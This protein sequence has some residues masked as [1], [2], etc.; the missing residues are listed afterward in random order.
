MLLS[1]VTRVASFQ[2]SFIT[3]TNVR[4]VFSAKAS[5]E[6][7]NDFMPKKKEPSEGNDGP[8]IL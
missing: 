2:R 3:G 6:S 8:L 1:R 5:D 7:H 4:R